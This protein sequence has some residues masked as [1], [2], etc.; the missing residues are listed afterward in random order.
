M[1]A[2]HRDPAQGSLSVCTAELLLLAHLLHHLD[3]PLHPTPHPPFTTLPL[4]LPAPVFLFTCGSLQQPGSLLVRRTKM[5]GIEGGMDGGREGSKKGGGVNKGF[6]SGACRQHT[7]C[8]KRAD[9]RA[10]Q[11]AVD[12]EGMEGW[13]SFSSSHHFLSPCIPTDELDN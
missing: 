8:L 6:V 12:G 1:G 9:I 2:E 7:C 5:E 11:E 10:Q 13:T 4:T 3:H